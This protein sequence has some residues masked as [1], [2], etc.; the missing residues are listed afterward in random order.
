[1]SH[2]CGGVGEAG[3]GRRQRGGSSVLDR[4]GTPP[5]RCCCLSAESGC[6]WPCGWRFGC[7]GRRARHRRRRCCDTASSLHI[8]GAA[9]SN[10]AVQP[11]S[12][13]AVLT[14]AYAPLIHQD[15]NGKLAPGLAVSW[16]Y[17]SG[18]KV[19]QLTLRHDAH[20]SDGTLVTASAVA[21]WLNYYAHAKAPFSSSLGPNP[22]FRPKNEWTVV[23]LKQPDPD[24]A[25]QLTQV[26]EWGAIASPKAV[27]DPSLLKSQT[28][29][30]GPYMLDPSQSVPGDH[31]VFVPNR[32]YY[33]QSAVK[34][35]QVYLKA[36]SDEESMLQAEQAGQF[37]VQW[38][39]DSTTAKAAQAAGLQLSSAPYATY[40]FDLNTKIPAFAKL[41]VREAL[42]Y[43]LDRKAITKALFGQYGKTTSEAQET[44]DADPGL[45]NYYPYEPAK[46]KKLLAEAGYPHGFSTTLIDPSGIWQQPS[47]VVAHYLQAVGVNVKVI[48]LS[49]PA[50]EA[51]SLKFE[52][53]LTAAGSSVGTTTPTLYPLFIGPDSSLRPELAVDPQVD[54]LYNAGLNA[55]N[56]AP[57]WKRMWSLLTKQATFLPF[58][59]SSE[60]LFHSKSLVANIGAGDPWPD[61]SE[62]FFKS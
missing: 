4:A 1:M 36:F 25:L 27:A 45:E 42:N 10:P 13:S 14:L 3:R 41:K 34:F 5:A 28:D 23:A 22:S 20:F 47:E 26:L 29:G 2:E 44:N 12:D 57:D 8:Q 46:A 62:W 30:A 59:V 43:A 35:S 39:N 19:F 24:V 52:D 15:P 51:R 60:F 48:T 33:D 11:F 58:S 37:D 7:R 50:W 6:C 21:K 18:H 56:P 16:G 40:Y 38:I 55:K 32:H 54:K 49:T 31:W 17:V 61:P 53:G 9:A